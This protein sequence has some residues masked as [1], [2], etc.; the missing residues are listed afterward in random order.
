MKTVDVEKVKDRI[1]QLALRLD[2]PD[3]LAV[4]LFGS[5]ARGDFDDRSDIDV[6]VITAEEI[7]LKEQDQVYCAFSKLIPQFKRDVTVLVYDLEAVKKVPTWQT[8]N[9]LRDARFVHDRGQIEALFQRILK[10]AEE[11]GIIYDV[12]DK[13]F[14][15]KRPGRMVFSYSEQ[16]AG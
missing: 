8:L 13:V 1:R 14:K 10:Q 15:L 7:P 16:V 4:G 9:M 3:V 11:H 12:E 5:L 2:R 6:F